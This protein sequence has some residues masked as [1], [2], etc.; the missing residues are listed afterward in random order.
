MSSHCKFPTIFG[1][2]VT[3]NNCASKCEETERSMLERIK[4]LDKDT[5]LARKQLEYNNK[6]W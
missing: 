4:E 1:N 2:A 3:E 6:T 5:Q